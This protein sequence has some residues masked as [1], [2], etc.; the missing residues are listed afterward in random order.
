MS[1]AY[2]SF[3]SSTVP[4]RGSS[5][6][7]AQVPSAIVAPSAASGMDIQAVVPTVVM[8]M[9]NS[10]LTFPSSW[11][12]DKLVTTGFKVRDGYSQLLLIDCDIPNY[13]D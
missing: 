8:S 3:K 2:D 10:D 1:S 12:T 6:A 11:E 13:L 7:P 5:S 4:V 9:L